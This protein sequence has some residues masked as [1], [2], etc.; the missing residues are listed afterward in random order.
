MISGRQAFTALSCGAITTVDSH[1]HVFVRGLKLDHS[2]RYAPDYDAGLDMYL[3]TLDAH[4][5]SHGV[6]VQPSFLGT[7][8]TF[9]VE[10][11]RRQFPRL[12]GIAV[13]DPTAD[14]DVLDELATVGV[15]GIRL[16]VVGKRIPDLEA[17]P[18][19]GLLRW[20]AARGWQVEVHCEADRL[21]ALIDPLLETGTSIVVDH[22]GRPDAD[23][24]V[25]D[26]GFIY[27]LTV[28]A[29]RRVW[30]KLS[31]TYRNGSNGAGETTAR[32][33]IPLLRDAYGVERLMW[34]SDWP[35]TQFESDMEFGHTRHLVD[36]W[37]T[38]PSE[39]H[40]VLV[41]TPATLFGFY[42]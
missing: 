3:R 28:G 32:A 40:A 10:A 17:K 36:D 21:Q 2:R 23:L 33:A 24:G 6:L 14:E 4:Q 38:D 9:L 25:E 41:D 8:N 37:F 39:R 7:D 13:V 31:G 30:I 34:G 5:I 42:T 20:I 35:H 27:L 22:F 18:W 19:S 29:S 11:I 26:P 1:A 15:V 12:R 16:N